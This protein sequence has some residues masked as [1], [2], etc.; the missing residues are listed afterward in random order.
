MHFVSSADIFN[1]QLFLRVRHGLRGKKN[2]HILYIHI[3]NIPVSNKKKKKII[4][5]ISFLG[6]GRK[7][8]LKR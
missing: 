2:S 8:K 1:S 6:D 7:Y 3:F 4:A 5:K